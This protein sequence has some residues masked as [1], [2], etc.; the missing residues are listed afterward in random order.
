MDETD[1]VLSPMQ[2]TVVTEKPEW[3]RIIH[4]FPFW[5]VAHEWDYFQAY[6]ARQRE[7]SSRQVLLYLERDGNRI[8]YPFFLKE[9]QE[10]EY[11]L[12]AVYGYTGALFTG[13]DF[14]GSWANF[15][16]EVKRF[17]VENDIVAVSEKFHPLLQNQY[18]ILPESKPELRR[19]VVL[20]RTRSGDDLLAN[21]R[22]KNVRK[23]VR[24]ARE[25]GIV[26]T[27]G[28]A[29]GI[30]EA[31]TLYRQTM[32][33]NQAED[34]YYFEKGFFEAF[35]AELPGRCT[36]FFAR[37]GQELAAMTLALHSPH[38]VYL[39]VGGMA[40]EYRDYHPNYLLQHEMLEHFHAM[41]V[42]YVNDGGGRTS[43]P[44]DSLLIFKRGFTKEEPVDY[45]VG[46]TPVSH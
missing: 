26:V 7:C 44:D 28:G 24:Q 10:G 29:E 35:F 16:G 39:F 2:L 9:R 17:C 18:P 41:G 38:C 3:D 1:E 14:D 23:R 42:P 34:I 20:L 22:R 40:S 15:Q 30:E 27:T 13:T 31:L 11:V 36:F 43:D 21:Y 5:D 45:Y 4:S 32:R 33:R 12:E 6:R 25:K 46:S 37:L 8:A 19:Q